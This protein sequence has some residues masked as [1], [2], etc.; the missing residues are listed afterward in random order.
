M[1][2]F[3]WADPP[4]DRELL[5]RARQEA[6]L[7]LEGDPELRRMPSIGAAVSQRWGDWLGESAPGGKGKKGKVAD[8]AA[9]RRRRR[10]RRR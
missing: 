4:R 9:N 3:S 10:R 7:L 5:L 8:K 2:E 1:P 6:F